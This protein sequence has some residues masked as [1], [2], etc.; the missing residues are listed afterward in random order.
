MARWRIN[1]RDPLWIGEGVIDARRAKHDNM[2][3]D[4]FR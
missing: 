2:R 3:K 4:N 1:E